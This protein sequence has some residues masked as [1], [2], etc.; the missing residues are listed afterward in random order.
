MGAL[1]E[2]YEDT[3]VKSDPAASGQNLDLP[4]N[5]FRLR[6]KDAARSRLPKP[7]KKAVDAA[8]K[9]M[10]WAAG[11]SER[12]T[13]LVEDLKSLNEGLNFISEKLN[14]TKVSLLP[15]R[16]L[17][18]ISDQNNLQAVIE[19]TT[20]HDPELARCAEIKKEVLAAIGRKPGSVVKPST[21]K[22]LA[23]KVSKRRKLA[24]TR[25]VLAEYND[26]ATGKV[27]PV[28]LE[29][30]TYGD[31]PPKYEKFVDS[32]IQ[33]VAGRFYETFPRVFHS[34]SKQTS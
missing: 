8:V 5:L 11:E 19:A 28:L 1:L 17:P 13:K 27:E 2:K 18:Y 25:L 29:D 6:I 34:L 20:Q 23:P 3:S 22:L 10:T 16:L 26:K 15:S 30:R 9:P 14:N 4:E 21:L 32:R 31:G 24:T 12:A 33:E 7:V